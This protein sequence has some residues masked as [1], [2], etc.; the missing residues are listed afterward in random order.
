MNQIQEIALQ[1]AIELRQ[2]QIDEAAE[3]RRAYAGI[4]RRDRHPVRRAIG[5]SLVRLGH[6]LANETEGTLQPA[7]HR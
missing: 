2:R 6:A 4:E 1:L 7:R 5:R 3:H